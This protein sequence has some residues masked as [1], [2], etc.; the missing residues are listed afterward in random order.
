M[1]GLNPEQLRQWARGVE[2]RLGAMEAEAGAKQELSSAEVL[3]RIKHKELRDVKTRTQLD[4]KLLDKSWRS[5]DRPCDCGYDHNAIEVDGQ[6]M[7]PVKYYL[8]LGRLALFGL[9]ETPSKE[10]FDALIT[11]SIE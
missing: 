2:A 7:C 8:I 1:D 10:L 9:T 6:V 11:R 5:L 4:T 3:G